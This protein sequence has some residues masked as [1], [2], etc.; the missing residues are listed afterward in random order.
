MGRSTGALLTGSR[1][2]SA[3]GGSL[4]RNAGNSSLQSQGKRPG[5]LA[6]SS[7]SQGQEGPGPP[8]GLRQVAVL[9]VPRWGAGQGRCHGNCPGCRG[10]KGHLAAVAW[11]GASALCTQTWGPLPLSSPLT[12]S[13]IFPRQ[14]GPQVRAGCVG[15]PG[16][17]S[18]AG[19]RECRRG[20]LT[21]RLCPYWTSIQLRA[22]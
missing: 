6:R 7:P 15:D 14:A 13:T 8:W 17:W 16:R 22:L 1:K 2:L 18:D 4:T 9:C 11:P 12:V 3:G 19:S 5:S 21:F 20:R 10:G